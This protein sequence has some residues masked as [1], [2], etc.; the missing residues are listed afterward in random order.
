MIESM[1]TTRPPCTSKYYVVVSVNTASSSAEWAFANAN[2]HAVEGPRV[3]SQYQRYFGEFYPA[4][5]ESPEA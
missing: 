5:Y 1:P 3:R 2:L 4:Q